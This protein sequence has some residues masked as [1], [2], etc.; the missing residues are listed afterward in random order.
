MS[1]LI[2]QDDGVFVGG[3]VDMSIPLEDVKT[4]G[5]LGAR[6]SCLKKK[7]VET[8]LELGRTVHR[9]YRFY[10]T[11]NTKGRKPKKKKL[12]EQIKDE[13]EWLDFLRESGFHM[14]RDHKVLR[15]LARI[16]ANADVFSANSAN[17]PSSVETLSLLADAKLP[18]ANLSAV[19]H[20]LTPD[21][22]I[23]QAKTA[24]KLVVNQPDLASGGTLAPTH[25]DTL[26]LQ[27]KVVEANLVDVAVGLAFGEASGLKLPDVAALDQFGGE[28]SAIYKRLL[29]ST[30]FAVMKDLIATIRGER[31]KALN[32][33]FKARK[34]A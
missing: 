5:E 13:N 29:K 12:P 28:L 3:S 32:N 19:L 8:I 9:A 15:N 2:F 18:A 21:F 4:G 24:L 1:N 27:I 25:P 33:A 11:W 14:P 7:S 17:L 34:A 20:T 16:G 31:Q 22:T 26:R 6:A 23:K 30:E 10:D